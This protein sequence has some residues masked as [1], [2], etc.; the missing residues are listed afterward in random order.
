M[1]LFFDVKFHESLLFFALEFM[2]GVRAPLLLQTLSPGVLK[3]YLQCNLSIPW[4]IGN[5]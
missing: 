4:P 2:Q 5:F 1:Y 3:R